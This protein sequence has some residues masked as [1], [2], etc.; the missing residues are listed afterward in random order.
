MLASIYMQHLTVVSLLAASTQTVTYQSRPDIV[1]PVFNISYS[2][3]QLALADG[4][5]FVGVRG[6]LPTSLNILDAN[7]D[8]VYW[9]PLGLD[10][11]GPFNFRPQVLNG[12]LVLTYWTGLT[13][14]EHGYGHVT[15]LKQDYTELATVTAPGLTKSDFHESRIT[16]DGTLLT[17]LY[18]TKINQDTSTVPGGTIGTTILDACFSELAISDG[19]ELFHFCLHDAG[20]PFTESYHPINSSEL[21]WDWAHPNAVYKDVLGNYVL[22]ARYMHTVY[23][24]S[25]ASGQILW[26]L[27]GKNSTFS[28][29]GT[30]FSWQ[31]D[32][33]FVGEGGRPTSDIAYAR[34]RRVSLFNNA[35][36]PTEHDQIVSTGIVVEIDFA[37]LTA[38][39]VA[40]FTTERVEQIT[41]TSQGNFEVYGADDLPSPPSKF[42]GGGLVS[43][44]NV[45]AFA[46]FTK[47]GT[48]QRIVH[49]GDIDAPFPGTY[50]TYK[51]PWQGYPRTAPDIVVRQH[52]L[53]VSWNGATSVRKW[54]IVQGDN[55][56]TVLRTGFE[57]V[58]ALDAKTEDKVQAIALDYADNE[59]G[60]SQYV[61]A[62]GLSTEIGAVLGKGVPL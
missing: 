42:T 61:L 51:A 38:T 49:W 19:N 18:E 29:S 55:T 15:I 36:T 28:G 32:A 46:E 30:D 45:P 37:A 17:T 11:L 12:D 60:R 39:N 27:G 22:S 41:A 7:G 57:T 34:T 48:L 23:Y 9:Q 21:V 16:R 24:I 59:L 31:H 1:K 54:R 53:Y 20:V 14:G 44:G 58:V 25:S 26:K 52:V 62:S 47:N 40:N 13:A 35:N 33:K 43:F 50:R 2:T 56:T 4:S 10:T 8:V 6:A 3:P 5:Y